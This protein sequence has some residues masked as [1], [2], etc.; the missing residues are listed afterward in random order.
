TRCSV[1]EQ[2]LK[3]FSDVADLQQLEKRLHAFDLI[4]RGLR[5]GGPIA[6]LPIA[7]RFRWLTA[8]RSTVVQT[9][10]VHPGMCVHAEETLNRL[11]RQLVG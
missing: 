8:A 2:R 6:K 10:P 5:E 4:C 9:S 1:N 3:S 11:F 7:S